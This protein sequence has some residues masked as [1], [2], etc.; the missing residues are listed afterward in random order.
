MGFSYDEGGAEFFDLRFG[1]FEIRL[2]ITP[3]LS[4]QIDEL[5]RSGSFFLRAQK[6]FSKVC[7]KVC[8]LS[9]RRIALRPKPINEGVGDAAHSAALLAFDPRRRGHWPHRVL[10]DGYPEEGQSEHR[11]HISQYGEIYTMRAFT[12]ACAGVG[13]DVGKCLVICS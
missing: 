13:N 12:G 11:V 2:S 4:G 10:S 5:T 1:D 6:A 7:S 8:D 9:E 3:K